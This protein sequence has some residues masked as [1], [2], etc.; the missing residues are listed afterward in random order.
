MK[1]PETVSM[2]KW[3]HTMHA[4]HSQR[5]SHL[6]YYFVWPRTQV[7]V[8]N[9]ALGLSLVWSDYCVLGPGGKASTYQANRSTSSQMVA[10]FGQLYHL[11]P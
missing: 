3:M 1:L 9:L 2:L 11:T 7:Q 4:S 6:Y 5:Q 8:T 10:E